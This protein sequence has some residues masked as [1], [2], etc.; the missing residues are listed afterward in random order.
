MT[1]AEQRTARSRRV[2]AELVRS[3]GLRTEMEEGGARPPPAV[4]SADGLA[5]RWERLRPGW[6]EPSLL[7]LEYLM[8]MGDLA[9]VRKALETLGD[10]DTARWRAYR[11]RI[12]RLKAVLDASAR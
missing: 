3:A 9:T 12:A 2:D 10:T 6:P 4:A 11:A 5:G 8:E 1:V 7:A